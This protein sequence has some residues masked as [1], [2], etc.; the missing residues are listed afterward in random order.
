[1]TFV[2]RR[3]PWGFAFPEVPSTHLFS[4]P[5]LGVALINGVT[6]E[7]PGAPGIRSAAILDPGAV[8]SGEIGAAIQRLTDHGVLSIGIRSKRATVHRVAQTIEHFPYDLLLISTHCGDAAGWRW[9]YEFVDSEGIGR[10]LVTDIA[11][12]VQFVPGQEDVRVT[13]FERFVSLDGVDWN[14]P[15]RHNKLYHGHAM[16]DFVRMKQ[17]DGGL[18]PTR[19]E[20]IPRVPGSMA[21]K[22][23]D[24]NYIALPQSLA[25][26]GAPIIIN[27]A[28]GS[29]HRLAGTF[30][31]ANARAYIGTLFSVLDPE[32]QAV[33]EPL[34]GRYFDKPLSVAL[35]R[36]QNDV[37]GQGVRRPYVIVGCHFQKLG[38][39]PR[40][41]LGCVIDQLESAS[42]DWKNQLAT[43]S[44]LTK[45]ARRTIEETVKYVDEHLAGLRRY[46]A[47]L[48]GG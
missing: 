36:A 6:A 34:F 1:M 26:G 45:H 29:W 46:R 24:H 11:I 17:E 23:A 9:T 8:D 19:K 12:G 44:E 33:I 43:D 35:W 40:D 3:I 20:E 18:E 4:Y 14:D 41:N 25:S 21:L 22:M 10:T 2:S 27:N 39:Q 38:A 42:A 28:C 13:Q 48:R 37:A 7:Q 5:D 15:E 47:S 32:A 31:F 30:M 16:R